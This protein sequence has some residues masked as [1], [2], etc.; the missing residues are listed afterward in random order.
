[1][2]FLHSE[3]FPQCAIST[4][5]RL[6]QICLIYKLISDNVQV[7]NLYSISECHDVSY[8][9]LT[10]VFYTQPSRKYAPVGQ[11]IPGVKVVVIDVSEG[12]KEVPMGVPGEVDTILFFELFFKKI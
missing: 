11:V 3:T 9:N 4:R 6:N 5:Q 10:E 1:M 8:S 2:N 7:L 12:L